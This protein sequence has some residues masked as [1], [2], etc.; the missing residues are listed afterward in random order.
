MDEALFR[1]GKTWDEYIN[2]IETNR[3]HFVGV[4]QTFPL[5]DDDLVVFRNFKG[6]RVVAIG[7]DWCPDVYNSMGILA[8]ICQLVPG[9]EMRIF[10]RD[11]YP[12]LMDQYLSDGTKKRIPVYAFFTPDFRQLCWW[13][14]RNRE[15]DAWVNAFRKGRPYDQIPK[16]ERDSFQSEFNGLYRESFARGN[17]EEI[18]AALRESAQAQ[19]A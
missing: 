9:A 13:A 15:A 5:T 12:E 16:A 1:K 4:Y 10:E 3:D 7:E 6:L 8:R 19:A 17:L 18:K 14:G 2:S 11:T